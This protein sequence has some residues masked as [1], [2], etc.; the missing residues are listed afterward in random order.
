V[1]SIEGALRIF[2]GVLVLSAPVDAWAQFAG[3][4]SA[5]AQFESDSNVFSLDSGASQTSPNG[6]VPSDTFYSYGAKLDG[7]YLWGLQTLTASLGATEYNYQRFTQL[8]H[9]A[10]T[11]NGGW[12][13][14]ANSILDGTLDVAR[15]RSMVQFQDLRIDET[16]LSVQTVQRESG[17]FNLKAT[18]HWQIQ[19]SAYTTDLEEP[20]QGAPDLKLTE[21]G[22]TLGLRYLG[23]TGFTSGVTGGYL[24]GSYHGGITT[25]TT[26]TSLNP[27]YRQYSEGLTATYQSVRSTFDGQIGYSRRTSTAGTDDTGGLTGSFSLTEKLTSKTSFQLSLARAIDNYVANSGSEIDTSAA[28]SVNWQ[29]TYKLGV[30]LGYTFSHANYPAQGTEFSVSDRVDHAQYATF[31]LNYQPRRWL[32]IK[33]YANYATRTSNVSGGD[34]NATSIGVSVTVQTLD[35]GK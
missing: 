9:N 33:P 16:S 7:K 34:Y 15:E 24:T 23:F 10:Y 22:A 20:N 8:D 17:K 31:S 1:P 30:S 32:L 12:Q 2:A 14:K 18:S 27:S 21:S 35:R 19:G 26:G 13:W 6:S 25:G 5:T 11:V 4:A 28:G 3:K 29:A